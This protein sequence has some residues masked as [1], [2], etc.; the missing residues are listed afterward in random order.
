M[1]LV[2]N[3]DQRPSSGSYSWGGMSTH[4]TNDQ[5]R[6]R[7]VAADLIDT[8]NPMVRGWAWSVRATLFNQEFGQLNSRRCR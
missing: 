6:A 3:Q 1:V 5:S 4:P 2:F 7:H 8:L